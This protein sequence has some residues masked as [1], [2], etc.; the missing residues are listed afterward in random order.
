MKSKRVWFGLGVAALL[1][2]TAFARKMAL[3]PERSQVVGAWCGYTDSTEFLR[4]ELDD[5]GTGL[6]CVT[7]IPGLHARLYR[8]PKWQYSDWHLELS[9][10]PID[11]DA[12][13]VVLTNMGCSDQ[14][15]EW[16]FGGVAGWKRK[17]VLFSEREWT[18]RVQP[19]RERI[20]SYRK[21]RR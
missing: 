5:D 15:M 11:S 17:A 7:F 16:Q 12:E 20:A 6:L 4:L 19:L 9:T 3:P 2:I 14:S 13:P 10:Q 1:A 8:I 21:E 18:S